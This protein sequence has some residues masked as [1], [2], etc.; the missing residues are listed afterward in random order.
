MAVCATLPLRE[1]VPHYRIAARQNTILWS[2]S[3]P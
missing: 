3:L 2:S 1:T